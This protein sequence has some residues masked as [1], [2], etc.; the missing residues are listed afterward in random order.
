MDTDKIKNAILNK[1]VQQKIFAGI[2]SSLSPLQIKFYPGDTAIN[3]TSTTGCIGMQVGSN[4][5]LLKL[6][7]KFVVIGVI[8]NPA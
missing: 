1:E 7:N 6:E 5:I 8:G 3:V 2:I 4:V